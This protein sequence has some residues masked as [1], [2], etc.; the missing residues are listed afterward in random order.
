M[1]KSNMIDTICYEMISSHY[2][3]KVAKRSGV[4][5]MKHIDEGLIILDKI[6]ANKATKAAYCLHPLVQGDADLVNN[7][8]EVVRE[9]SLLIPVMLA[10]EYRSVA[11]EYLSTRVISDISE[12]RLSP[13]SMVNQ[14]LIADKV[15]NR[16]D[17]DLYHK[18]KHPR[19]KELEQYFENW[20][21]R[22][23]VSEERYVELISLLESK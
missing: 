12:I 9:N 19:S 21:R 20:L 10:M 8:C 11:N 16:K 4:P 13:L 18:G 7:F 14:M 22:L 5:Y 3:G 23:G 15:Q 17:F 6:H 1:Y 2:E